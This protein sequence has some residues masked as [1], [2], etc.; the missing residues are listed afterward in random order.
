MSM[1]NDYLEMYVTL[2]RGRADVYGHNE[3]R[4]VKQSLTTDKFM[5]HLDGTEPIG[6]YPMVPSNGDHYV[7]WGCSDFDTADAL[8]HAIALH[9]A[10]Q[11]AGIQSWIE[12]SRSKGFHVW[13]FMAEPV[14]AKVMRNALLVAHQV[15]DVPATE[16]NPKQYNLR[17]G[18]Y[19]NY[20]RLP[21]PDANADTVHQRIVYR[22]QLPV[23]TPMPFDQFVTQ[24]FAGRNPA[25]LLQRVSS[26]YAEQDRPATPVNTAIEYDASL[27][28]AMAV[29]SPLGKVI[30]RDGPLAG[31]DRSSTL[32]KLGHEC[33]RSGLNPSQTK[34]IVRTADQRWGKYHLRP[35]GDME[36]DK[37]VVR[38]HS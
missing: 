12:R 31:R 7:A 26:L 23:V 10:L 5:S 15:A 36:I 9:D 29:L 34:V 6:V 14:T 20:V 8:Y 21:Y 37:L 16:V 27:D 17:H 3:G 19:G 2:F 13:V 1:L 22:D 33:V 18:Q 4:C 32:T 35:N 28:E 11:E 30:W 38:V 25:N 24:A